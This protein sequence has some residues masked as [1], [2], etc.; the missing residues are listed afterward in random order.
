MP[1]CCEIVLCLTVGRGVGT[2]SCLKSSSGGGGGDDD[3]HGVHGGV[4][5]CL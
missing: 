1:S 5:R 4:D 2:D 3:V